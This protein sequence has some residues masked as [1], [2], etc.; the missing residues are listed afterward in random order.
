MDA[1]VFV[2]GTL[3]KNFPNHERFLGRARWIG[4]YR[5][6]IPFP[7]VLNGERCSPCLIDRPG[8]GQRVRGEVYQVNTATLA[9]LDRL[10]R[11]A[12]NDGYHRRL[13]EVVSQ[14]RKIQTRLTV[15]AYFKASHLV[16]A[17]QSANLSAYTPA[18]GIRYRPRR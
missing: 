2:Y 5:T 1:F 3:K 7:L 12:A 18:M 6:V 4:D 11:T 14:D 10:E 16:T 17:P 8:A 13:I 15:Y 9:A